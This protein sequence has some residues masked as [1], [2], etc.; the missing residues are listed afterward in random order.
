MDDAPKTILLVD[1]EPG[2]IALL[3]GI[4]PEGYK[5]KIA[6]N[7]EKA[8]EIARKAPVPDLIFL[9]VM[10]PGLDGY[11]V[12]R[13]LKTDAAT[14]AI[15]IVFVSGHADDAE[16]EKG[17]QLGAVDFMSK[18]VDPGVIEAA[19]FRICGRPA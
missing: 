16:R 4:I 15:P 19:I 1:D 7:G 9:D 12:C 5:V 8:L 2:N 13:I 3:K 14:A 10:M 18:P 6:I 11:E 17:R